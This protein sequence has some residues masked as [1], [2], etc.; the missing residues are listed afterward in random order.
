[1]Q[2]VL[3]QMVGY[4]GQAG[5]HIA[6]AQVLGADDLPRGGFDQRRAA[7]KN[8]ALVFDDDG[9]ITH[10]RHI[11]AAGSATAHHHRNL[12]DALGAHMRLVIKNSAKVVPVGKD[13]VLVGQ[14]GAA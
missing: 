7:Q 12:R 3:R 5:V 14:I 13:V 10:G 1:M 9:L 2:I 8:R 4:A 6:T 11:G